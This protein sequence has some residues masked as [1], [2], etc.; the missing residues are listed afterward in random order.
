MFVY[1]LFPWE[2]RVSSGQRMRIDKYTSISAP[3]S[4]S[5]D[6]TTYRKMTGTVSRTTSEL[7]HFP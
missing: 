2:L 1:L 5:D 3:T 4:T 7:L 6:F